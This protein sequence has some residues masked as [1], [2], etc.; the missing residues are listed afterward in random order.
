MPHP[1][2]ATITSHTAPT[3]PGTARAALIALSVGGFGIGLTEFAVASLLTEIA[4]SLDVSISTAGNLVGGYAL[5]VV[6][7]ALIITPLLMRRTPKYTLIMLLS[8]FSAGNALSAWAP[9]YGV[10]LGGRIIAA[11]NHG[12]YFGISAVLAAELVPLHRRASAVAAVFAG[13]TIAN[14]L[15]VCFGA[16]IGQHLGWRTVFWIISAVG[17]VA[18]AG[19]A[20]C[21][22]R[23][24]P[25][26]A[27]LTLAHQFRVLV[28]PEVLAA[29]TTT[30]LAF[31]GVVGMFTF[32]EPILRQ[33]TGYLAAAIPWLLVLFGL[34]V[35]LGNWVGGRFA[36]LNPDI[37]V[38]VL[39]AVLPVVIL[40]LVVLGI[41]LVLAIVWRFC[42]SSAVL[43]NPWYGSDLARW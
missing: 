5:A 43:D 7:S 42:V 34:G 33:I 14:A 15:G 27:S 16:F 21:V 9:S 22:P 1:N 19:L 13:L 25:E 40:A 31:G 4:D 20:L 2:E 12:G 28:Q 38:L 37:A 8:L 6:P 10:M 24:E 17:V 39:M 32:I 23:T 35:T 41:C 29:L 11:L 3:T 36:D 18:L 26:Q 30:M